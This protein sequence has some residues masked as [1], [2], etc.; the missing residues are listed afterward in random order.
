MGSNCWKHSFDGTNVGTMICRI[1]SVE[2]LSGR[3]EMS[4][5]SLSSGSIRVPEGGILGRHFADFNV[6]D[7]VFGL[8]KRIESFGLFI[9]IE[10]SSLVRSLSLVSPMP[11]Q[12]AMDMIHCQKNALMDA[13]MLS[14]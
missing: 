1:V 12:K 5:K 4:L 10:Q 9:S 8:I 2:H 3:V 13:V 14:W 6:G 11:L 7:I